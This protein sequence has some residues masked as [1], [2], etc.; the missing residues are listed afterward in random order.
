[1]DSGA[2]TKT[3]I[4]C[5]TAETDKWYSGPTCRRCYRYARDSKRRDI[6]NQER[7]AYLKANPGKRKEYEQR[8][9]VVNRETWLASQ[10]HR[11]AKH[12]AKKLMA[13][14]EWVDNEALKLIYNNCPPGHH[15][16]H[17]IPLKNSIVSGLH[18]PWNLQYLP[19]LENIAKSNKLT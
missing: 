1:M 7:K 15:V 12:R 13:T 2:L 16:D 17:I 18:V 14:P 9:Q 4:S 5:S 11:E 8:H 3:C 19:A 10:K 6:C